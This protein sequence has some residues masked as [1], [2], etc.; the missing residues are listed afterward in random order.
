MENDFMDQDRHSPLHH[1]RRAL[2]CAILV[3]IHLLREV[4]RK[5]FHSVK[6]RL[7]SRRPRYS[8]LDKA[9]RL[10]QPLYASYSSSRSIITRLGFFLPIRGR[11]LCH[12]LIKDIIAG[13]FLLLLKN[14][15][16]LASPTMSLARLTNL[17]RPT[18]T[19]EL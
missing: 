10:E 9:T 8:Y 13:L 11:E 4:N 2:K 6:L 3:S 16:F 18:M 5:C 14:L 7:F 19:N 1:F 17:A 15:W 12:C